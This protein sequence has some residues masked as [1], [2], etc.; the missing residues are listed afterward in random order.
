MIL[1]P[2]VR[3]E[4]LSALLGKKISAVDDGHPAKAAPTLSFDDFFKHLILNKKHSYAD[5]FFINETEF[6]DP[7]YDFDFTNLSD[8]ADCMRGDET[9]E[10]PI[11]WYRMALKVKGKYPD[12]N[13]WLGPDG[14]RSYS[15]PGEWP[16]SYHGT[17]IEGARGIISTHYKP[18]HR[19]LY[20]RG[21]YSAPKLSIAETYCKTFKSKFTGKT[22]EMVMQNRI[23]PEKMEIH[24][25]Y[26][27]IP[28]PAGT[29]P[30]E[31][32]RITESSIR[33]YGVLIREV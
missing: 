15:V 1:E 16:V 25:K 18:G 4:A 10:R 13:T 22:Y 14:W 5:E 3:F 31:E 6:F 19:Q 23:K 20:G 30:E 2:N 32:E 33:P 7:S 8:T 29:S 21:I 12:G 24:G 28:V 9:Y 27:L 26:W 17:G 11:G